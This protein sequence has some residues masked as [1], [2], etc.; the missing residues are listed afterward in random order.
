M[1]V[2]KIR[3]RGLKVCMKND[4]GGIYNGI[5]NYLTW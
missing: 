5:Y 4:Q 2:L 3:Q 1:N